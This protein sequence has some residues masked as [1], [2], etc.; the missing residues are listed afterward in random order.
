MK[1]LTIVLTVLFAFASFAQTNDEMKAYMDYLTPGPFHQHLAQSEG[2]WDYQ[3]KMFS[4]PGKAPDI[5][6]G[7]AKAEMILGGRY[8]QI[9]HDGTAWGMPFQA[10]QIFG[11]DNVKQEFLAFWID[12]MGTGFTFSSGKMDFEKDYLEMSGS[13]VDA[14][15]KKD[16]NFRSVLKSTDIDHFNIE[17]YV[18]K[19]GKESMFWDTSYS[20]KK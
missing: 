7:T 3:M 14:A 2:N 12:N 8:L 9:N 4:E 6:N 1:K 19:D 18:T 20:R 17:M 10:I 15:Q 5:E 13:F 16:V 11:F